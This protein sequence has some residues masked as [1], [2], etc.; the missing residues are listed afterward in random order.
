[1]LGVVLLSVPIALLGLLLGLPPGF[2]MAVAGLCWLLVAIAGPRRHVALRRP[3]LRL[4]AD[5]ADDQRERDGDPFEAF[6]RSYSYVYGKPLH[7]FWYV[8][9]AAAFGALCWAVVSVAA[10]LVQEFGFWAFSWGG[11][12][13]AVERRHASKRWLLG[14]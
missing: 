12:G 1:M 2:G 3:H 10:Q 11:G 8:V 6:S 5:V 7:Y 13:D 14:G 9:V 4:A